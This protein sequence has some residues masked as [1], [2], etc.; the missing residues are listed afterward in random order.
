MP[1]LIIQQK[2]YHSDITENLSETDMAASVPPDTL[3]ELRKMRFC[4]NCRIFE[5]EQVKPES[6]QKCG[7]CK[8]L[9]YCSTQ[10]Q[11]EHWAL[12]HKAQ[13]KKLAWARQ[14]EEVGKEPVGI[15]SQHPFPDHEACLQSGSV[16]TTEVLVALV[17]KVLV[18]IRSTNP[19][20]FLQIDQLPQL[21][22]IMMKN[23]RRIWSDR[24][25]LPEKFKD[26]H[27]EDGLS[28]DY[29]LFGKTSKILLTD[30]TSQN[31]W[32]ILH[33]VWGRL[34]GHMVTVRVSSL[35]DPRQAVPADAW[36]DFIEDDVG[37]FPVRLNELFNAFNSDR[38]TSFKML[39]KVF[40][41]GSLVQHCSFCDATMSV[42]AVY[43][44][45]CER[46]V[47]KVILLP[48][49]TLMYF[50]GSPTCEEEMFPKVKAW[51]KW[52][53]AIIMTYNSLNGHRCDFC[54]KLEE[55]AHR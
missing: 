28:S 30:E 11:A 41:G 27:I 14:S 1:R 17:Q 9:Q 40:C 6:L 31:A 5:W 12:V 35:K 38:F 32:S 53:T 39:L 44:G 7:R 10:C 16:E 55:E 29:P 20:L 54:F 18:Q 47:P 26:F 23:R 33:L 42:E 50:C 52:R 49:L 19:A 13:C 48:H 36:E 8:L 46:G 25:W 3:E 22:V 45:S 24:I 2:F 34:I 37:L 15:F 21:E 4:A 43:E 51:W